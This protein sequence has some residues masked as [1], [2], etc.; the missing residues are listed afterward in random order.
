M[1]N[2]VG[3]SAYYH[4][5]AAC[6][7]RDGVLVAAAQE[8]RFSRRK[9]DDSLP[10]QAF[11]YCLAEAGLTIAD[12]DCVAFYENP[13]VKLERRLSQ[14]WPVLT[15]RRCFEFWARARLPVNAIRM[16]LGYEG[17]IELCDHHRSHAAS[18]FLFSGFEESA[19]LTVDSVGE[20]ATT[21][22]GSGRDGTIELF[23]DVR[24]PHSLGLLYSTLTNYL[25][26][27]VNDGEYKVM[28]LAPYG[29]PR[30]LSALRELLHAGPAGQFELNARYFDFTRTDR[31]YTDALA[32]LV[33]CPPRRPGDAI[34][35]IHHDIAS[36]LQVLLEE[37]LLDKVR[38]LHERVPVDNLCMAGG[39][40]LNCVANG[41]ILRE[42]PFKRLFV[43]P[44]AGDAGGC[45]GAAALAHARHCGAATPRRRQLDHVYL[46]PAYSSAD[47]ARVLAVAGVEASDY[48]GR[49]VALIEAA[50]GLLGEGRILGWFQGRME[51]GPRALGARSILADPRDPSMQERVNARIKERERFRPFAPAVLASEASRFFALDHPSPFMLE[52]CQVISDVALPATTHV[53][54]SARVQTVDAHFH[55]RFAKLLQA[56]ERRTGCSVVLNTSFNLSDE[57]IVAS[58]ADALRSFARS[59]LDALV[60]EDFIVERSA[61]SESLV[62]SCRRASGARE[63]QRNAYTF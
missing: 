22:Y 42:G 36:S 46:G 32:D 56:F 58:P 26:F 53:D 51:F 23:E 7:L 17:E 60:I 14:Y 9:H 31:M 4:D 33:G 54:G 38:Y 44:A 13:A 15:P 5:A 21:A 18:A 29:R 52:T 30:L 28:G 55:P 6:V 12:V 24:F 20:W 45:V 11:R 2:V 1:F 37:V 59:E 62:A 16:M 8:E 57:P 43:Q 19:I 47:V 63:G 34:L 35:P 10:Q 48:R 41:R 39:V 49:E 25:G 3:I 50:A 27:A 61:L 40:A